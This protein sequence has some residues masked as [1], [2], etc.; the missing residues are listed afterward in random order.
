MFSRVMGR[1]AFLV[2]I[3]VVIYILSCSPKSDVDVHS[4]NEP[5]DS[6]AS[7]PAREEYLL[8]VAQ[9]SEWQRVEVSVK[10]EKRPLLL[11]RYPSPVSQESLLALSTAKDGP[12]KTVL[13]TNVSYCREANNMK[14]AED[15]QALGR[16][17]YFPDLAAKEEKEYVE[18]AGGWDKMLLI[19]QRAAAEGK[20][21]EYLGEACFKDYRILLF[22]TPGSCVLHTV[23]RPRDDGKYYL[24]N[25]WPAELSDILKKRRLE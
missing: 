5:S 4:G 15:A 3:A 16:Y 1:A 10:E 8:P 11:R 6:S 13:E 22:R 20:K 9:D 12:G 7:K 23:Y 17:A 25:R 24:M 19:S 14:T 2:M 21:K 18:R